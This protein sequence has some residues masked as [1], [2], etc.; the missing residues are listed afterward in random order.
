MRSRCVGAAGIPIAWDEKLKTL[1]PAPLH[2]WASHPA[3]AFRY[4]AMGL[5]MIES[6]GT[7]FKPLTYQIPDEVFV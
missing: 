6:Q 1:K 2:D 4:L 7:A 5:N 3:D